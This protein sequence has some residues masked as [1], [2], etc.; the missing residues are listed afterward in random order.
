MSRGMTTTVTD[1][2]PLPI[3]KQSSSNI[4]VRLDEQLRHL[5]DTI[6]PLYPYL[7]SVPSDVPY[8]HSSRF[9]N[10]WYEGTPFDKEEEQLQYL[11]FLPHQGEHESLLRVEGGWSD[12]HGN[13]VEEDEELSPKALPTSGR[14]TP[15]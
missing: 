14:H 2:A 10:T 13:P 8:R 15:A 1:I 4:V 12:D 5:T 9:V 11:S 7:L 3:S 6:L